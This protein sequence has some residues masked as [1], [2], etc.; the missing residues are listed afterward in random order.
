M[1]VAA[2]PAASRVAPIGR[3][4]KHAK[5]HA[6]G[7]HTLPVGLAAG[8]PCAAQAATIFSSQGVS[9]HRVFKQKGITV[10]QQNPR[11]G[12]Q[13]IF[14]CFSR[15]C[16]AIQ[17]NVFTVQVAAAEGSLHKLI[18]FAVTLLSDTLQ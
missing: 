6:K 10:T 4:P 14:Y 7:L 18:Y 12:I 11:L 8:L 15:D 13:A 1:G 3:S 2:W 9:C 17:G 5:Q 16:L